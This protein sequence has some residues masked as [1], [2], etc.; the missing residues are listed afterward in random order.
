MKFSVK[1]KLILKDMQCL[2]NTLY[3]LQSRI[4]NTFYQVLSNGYCTILRTPKMPPYLREREKNKNIYIVVQ[5][6]IHT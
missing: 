6:S 5:K 1:V 3:K 4:T 2:Y